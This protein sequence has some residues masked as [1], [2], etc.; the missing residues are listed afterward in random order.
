MTTTLSSLLLTLRARS[1][2]ALKD[3]DSDTRSLVNTLISGLLKDG[4]EPD[5][6]EG[7]DKAFS[8]LSSYKKALNDG[9][10]V[11]PYIDILQDLLPSMLTEDE[12]KK[13]VENN[14]L[15]N[16]GQAMKWFK[17]QP[18]TYFDRAL[19]KKVIDSL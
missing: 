17:E 9:G 11:Q 3:R 6:N 19:L 5:P 14:S 16:M 15:T 12:L 8:L 13:I 1:L 18:P 2:Q 4:K 10:D 7:L